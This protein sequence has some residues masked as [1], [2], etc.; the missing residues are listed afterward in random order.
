LPSGLNLGSITQKSFQN[1]YQKNY[2]KNSDD[3]REIWLVIQ[4]KENK[5]PTQAQPVFLDIEVAKVFF[6]LKHGKIYIF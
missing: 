4:R 2:K 5:K 1:N 6:Y 3:I